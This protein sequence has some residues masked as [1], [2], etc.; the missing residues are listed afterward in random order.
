MYKKDEEFVWN[1]ECI[2]V[3]EDLK[4]AVTEAPALQPVDYNLDFPVILAV[5]TSLHAVGMVILQIDEAG[6]RRP[7][8]YESIPLNK[9]EARYSQ[10]KLELYGLYRA[11]CAS[12]LI[13]SISK[14]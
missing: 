10:P 11:F 3:F 12:G 1:E 9:V 2:A 5:A 6:K 8:R 7:A 4:K 13:Q 14:G